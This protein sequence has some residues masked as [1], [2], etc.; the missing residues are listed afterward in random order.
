MAL[1]V[2]LSF[3]H[4]A[5]FPVEVVYNGAHLCNEMVGASL[6]GEVEVDT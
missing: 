6:V 5:S 3:N 2:V 1:A 4:R